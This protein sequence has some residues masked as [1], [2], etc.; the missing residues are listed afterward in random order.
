MGFRIQGET[1]RNSW[2]VPETG[3]ESGTPSLIEMGVSM[4]PCQHC[5]PKHIPK[6]KSTPVENHERA[7][8]RGLVITPSSGA[9]AVAV[10]A[11]RVLADPHH[12]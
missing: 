8:L 10:A 7:L 9:V 1:Y 2:M 4:T 6:T 11:V 5:I 3:V 12:L